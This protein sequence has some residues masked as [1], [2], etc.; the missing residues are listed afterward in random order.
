MRQLIRLQILFLLLLIFNNSFSQEGLLKDTVELQINEGELKSAL[1]ELSDHTGIRFGYREKT[2]SE[3]HFKSQYFKTTLEEILNKLLVSNQLCYLVQGKQII[4]HTGC[5]PKYYSISG[6]I[7]EESTFNSLPYISVSL[8][9]Q[10]IGVIA[11]QS[12]YFELDIPLKGQKTDTLI[13]S[14]LGFYRDTMILA[15]GIEEQITQLMLPKTYPVP[16]ITIRPMEY[17]SERLGNMKDKPSGSLY[18]DTHGQQT[19]LRIENPF[20]LKGIIQSVEYYLSKK[21]NTEAPFRVRIYEVDSTGKPGTDLIDDAIVV[22]PEIDR[23]WY[24]VDISMLG[25]EMPQKGVFVSIEGVFP[26]DY[27]SYFGSSEFIDLADQSKQINTNDLIYGQRVGYNRK[28]KKDTWHYSIN[29]IW[30]QLEKQSFGVMIAMVV[31]YEKE[32]ENKKNSNNE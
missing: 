11:D 28:G 5:L 29:K 15:A 1:Q 16:E 18:L 3:K 27:E 7:I 21:G 6:H 23:G 22:K 19:A 2:I 4:I 9:G 12:G 32:I 13:F 8:L 20:Q 17:V 24:S 26:D 25:I 10:P 30:F 31:K 14:S